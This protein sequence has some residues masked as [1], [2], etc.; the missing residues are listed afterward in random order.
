MSEGKR[1]RESKG[2]VYYPDLLTTSFITE[3]FWWRRI[4]L[5]SKIHIPELLAVASYAVW[6]P[7]G[8]G[9]FVHGH[10]ITLLW[11]PRRHEL[12]MHTAFVNSSWIHRA[13]PGRTSFRASRRG[14]NSSE[15]ISSIKGS[16]NSGS[17]RLFH[18]NVGNAC[19][20]SRLLISF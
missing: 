3:Q 8:T 19:L 16:K 12:Y 7:Q 9:S 15:F 11:V 18:E 2:A 5:C 10:W 14:R 6:G 4:S 1:E 17:L 13:M 20:F